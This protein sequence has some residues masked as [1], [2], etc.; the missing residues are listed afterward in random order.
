MPLITSMDS[1]TR[2]TN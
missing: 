2:K 1:R